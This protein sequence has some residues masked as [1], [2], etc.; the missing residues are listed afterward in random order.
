MI[1]CRQQKQYSQGPD[2][3][4]QTRDR[5]CRFVAAAVIGDDAAKDR[6][7]RVHQGGGAQ[8]GRRIHF[9]FD[10]KETGKVSEELVEIHERA[11]TLP[12]AS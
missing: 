9:S 10:E 8:Q 11:L 3:A 1:S 5:P 4:E 7:E 2:A 6:V 12:S